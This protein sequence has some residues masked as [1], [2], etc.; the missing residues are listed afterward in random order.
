MFTNEIVLNTT[1]GAQRIKLEDYDMVTVQFNKQEMSLNVYFTRTEMRSYKLSEPMRLQ[2]PQPTPSPEPTPNPTP[3]PTPE[4]TPELTPTTEP[5][6]RKRC[7]LG[8]PNQKH[9]RGPRK[10]SIK[11][12]NAINKF[13]ADQVADFYL[14]YKRGVSRTI[15]ATEAGVNSNTIYHWASIITRTLAGAQVATKNP[16]LKEA[17]E[18]IRTNNLL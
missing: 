3:E 1:R 16:R 6:A 15:L 9:Q 10:H 7:N 8:T 14:R 12:P 5:K 11:S 18:Y 4:T 17:A 13:T 2:N